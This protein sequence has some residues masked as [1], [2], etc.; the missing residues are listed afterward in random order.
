MTPMAQDR[1]DPACEGAVSAL[2]CMR[3]GTDPVEVSEPIWELAK[4]K[5]TYKWI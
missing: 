1:Q 3:I 4:A 2:Q 5:D